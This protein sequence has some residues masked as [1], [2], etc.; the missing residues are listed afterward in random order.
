MKTTIIIDAEDDPSVVEAFM[1]VFN[2]FLGAATN[3]MDSK[4]M[5][6]V[7]GSPAYLLECVRPLSK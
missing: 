4:N 7:C 1:K 6:N 2:G 3:F 5:V